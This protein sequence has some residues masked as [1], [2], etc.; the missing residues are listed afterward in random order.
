MF[1]Y[2]HAAD[3]VAMFRAAGVRTILDMH[4]VLWKVY[5]QRLSERSLPGPVRSLALSRY[6]AAEEAI[7]D[8]FDAL[9]AIN[10]REYELVSARARQ[11][12]HVFY[13][14]MGIDLTRWS[15]A[16]QPASPIRLAYYG[17]LGSQHNEAAALQ[18]HAEVMPAVW[19]RFPDAELWLVGSNP[20]E[21]L[22]RLTA[23][24]RV[25]VTGFVDDVQQV[26]RTMSLVLCPWSGTYGFRS[27]IVEVMALGVPVITMPD[28][29]DGMDLES[30]RGVVLV[31]GVTAMA[32]AASELLGDRRRLAE[33]SRLAREE[34]HRLYSL[35]STYGRLI[36]ELRQLL[37]ES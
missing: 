23:D 30:G 13:A 31:D 7:W 4:N 21:R 3:C 26:L 33:Q 17:G 28:A 11:G 22:R 2:F 34:M 6:R 5:E 10:R 18:C 37:S 36:R 27:R 32:A 24:P 20:S 9:V 14:P 29:L 12:Q 16:W 15:A 8:R 35:D 25:T 1:E 19:Q